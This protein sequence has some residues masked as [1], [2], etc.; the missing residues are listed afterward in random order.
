MDKSTY[1]RFL[2][3]GSE[4]VPFLSLMLVFLLN[5]VSEWLLAFACHGR[6]HLQLSKRKQTLPMGLREGI[7]A[8]GQLI[9]DVLSPATISRPCPE[10]RNGIT[11]K[12]TQTWA[13]EISDLQRPPPWPRPGCFSTLC[14]KL[15]NHSAG[16]R[17]KAP[18]KEWWH[19]HTNISETILTCSKIH[20]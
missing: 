5:F 8:L 3:L 1:I 4:A 17:N 12:Y 10:S 18:L 9:W 20:I 7:K 13:Q 2:S 15:G 11:D 6:E 14:S 16:R 19:Q